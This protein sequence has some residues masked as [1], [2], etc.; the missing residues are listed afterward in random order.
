MQHPKL[1]WKQT[2]QW[3]QLKDMYKFYPR[4]RNSKCKFERVLEQVYAT[5]SH[6]QTISS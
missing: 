4:Y 3:P 2:G 1:M 5:R 6:M